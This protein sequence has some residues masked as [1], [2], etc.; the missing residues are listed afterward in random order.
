MQRVLLSQP[1]WAKEAFM[2]TLITGSTWT[3]TALIT[4]TDVPTEGF[5]APITPD[6]EDWWIEQYEADKGR[7]F[8]ALVQLEQK[9]WKWVN[10]VLDLIAD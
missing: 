10:K 2:S 5:P 3:G 1:V 6:N 4:N 8:N 9:G 7:V